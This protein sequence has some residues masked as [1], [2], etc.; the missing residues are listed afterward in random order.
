MSSCC[1][2]G[3]CFCLRLL[4]LSPQSASYSFISAC[5]VLVSIDYLHRAH[6]QL[7]LCFHPVV[8]SHRW[9]S[10]QPEPPAPHHTQQR[11][12]RRPVAC[13]QQNA[14]N[15]ARSQIAD[16]RS[17]QATR[18]DRVA[19]LASDH[20]RC[21]IGRAQ[22][23]P[24]RPRRVTPRVAGSPAGEAAGALA[25]LRRPLDVAE[26]AGAR[27]GHFVWTIRQVMSDDQWALANVKRDATALPGPPTTHE[28]RAAGS[29]AAATLRRLDR[30]R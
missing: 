2:G 15:L 20:S 5:G 10:S 8:R 18:S 1:G 11:P 12:T 4:G 27:T 6:E 13:P 16:R 17:R 30:S 19:R 29:P 14:D 23:G 25:L 24:R 26:A 22:P 28:R 9:H 3:C 21:E 7:A